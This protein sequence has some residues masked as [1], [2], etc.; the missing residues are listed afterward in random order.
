VAALASSNRPRF[1]LSPPRRVGARLRREVARAALRFD[2]RRGWGAEEKRTL[3]LGVI[4]AVT[5]GA[6]AA[7]EVG[8]VWRRGSAPMPSETDDIVEAA[9]EAVVETVEAVL[10]GYQD[11]PSRE[12]AAFNLLASFVVTFASARGIAY[13]I[14]G[15]GRFGPFRNMIVGRRHVHHFVP[16]ITIAFISGAI[17]ILTRNEDIE[18]KLAIPYGIGMALTLDESALLLELEDVYWTRE[19]L[20]SLQVTLAT[21]ALIGALALAVRFLR[22][23]ER[24]VLELEDEGGQ[25]HHGVAAVGYP[26]PA[27]ESA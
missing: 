16:G 14:R 21:S 26:P 11:V 20:L 15:R 19:G 12:N 23:G 10:A 22:R 18:P 7:A 1:L 25:S 2:R 24:I 9:E 27:A 13:L 3:V 17:A 8:R 5:T 6:V 4:A